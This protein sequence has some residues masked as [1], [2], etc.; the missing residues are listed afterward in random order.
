MERGVT[1]T[2]ESKPNLWCFDFIML[3]ND[4]GSTARRI[5]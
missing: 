3:W 4:T 2:R 1:C 5:K